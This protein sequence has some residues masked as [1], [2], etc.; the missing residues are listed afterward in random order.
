MELRKSTQQATSASIALATRRK[1]SKVQKR[2]P[3]SLKVKL[4]QVEAQVVPTLWSALNE[5]SE[6]MTK[7][8]KRKKL[9]RKVPVA[10]KVDDAHKCHPD[11][12]VIEESSNFSFDETMLESEEE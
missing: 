9:S 1:D 7:T 6:K 11:N 2:K 3:K 4:Y 8:R 5:T 10:P 12:A